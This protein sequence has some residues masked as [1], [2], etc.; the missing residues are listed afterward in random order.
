MS[1]IKVRNLVKNYR[2]LDKE[3]KILDHLDLDVEEGEIV[4]VEGKSGIGKST[5]LNILGSMDSSDAGEVNVCGVSLD[6]ISETGK[7]KFRAEKVA[8]IFQ[9]HLLLP[10]FTALENV[11]IP[12]LINGVQPGKARQ[13]SIEMLDRVGLKDR[14]DNFPSQLSGGE[15]A[16]VGV[17]RALVA[18]KKLILAD[19]PTGN[20]DR[21][22]S[23]NLMALILELQKEFRFSIVI[24]TH[25]MELASLAHKRNQMAGGKLQPI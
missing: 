15:S 3:F 7:E 21:E 1:L 5:L 14:H 20:L 24:V 23:R 10:D 22:N 9:H 2:I 25:D 4:S 11:S 18:G 16:R 8:F 12:L 19:E 6:Q 17:A 13:L